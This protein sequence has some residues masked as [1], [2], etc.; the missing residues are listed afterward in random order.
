MTEM[1]KLY[2]AYYQ[3]HD[4]LILNGRKSSYFYMGMIERHIPE[5]AVQRVDEKD[6]IMF[7]S[8]NYFKRMGEEYKK[9][10]QFC[11]ECENSKNCREKR[12]D[13]LNR[14]DCI[15]PSFIN[16]QIVQYLFYYSEKLHSV[17]VYE[18]RAEPRKDD[19][20]ALTVS[21]LQ[22]HFEYCMKNDYLIAMKGLDF[23]EQKNIYKSF[24]EEVKK[25]NILIHVIDY[26]S[27]W[28]PEYTNF[29]SKS[30]ENIEIYDL[31]DILKL[32]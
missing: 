16:N 19:F 29:I 8:E 7:V 12:K 21:Y 2:D 9:P 30:I 18:R 11:K 3:K 5:I 32:I 14:E 28:I 26:A 13:I 27:K 17:I 10:A 15:I 25:E 1:E 20:G 6:P 31:F 23:N 24:K 4:N 22:G